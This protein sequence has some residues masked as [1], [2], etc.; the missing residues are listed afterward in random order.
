MK[1]ESPNW[2]LVW[3]VRALAAPRSTALVLFGG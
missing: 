3:A 2:V 1:K